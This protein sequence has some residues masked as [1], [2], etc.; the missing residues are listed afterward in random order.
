[1][2]RFDKRALGFVPFIFFQVWSGQAHADSFQGVLENNRAVHQFNKEELVE[3][4][5]GFTKALGDLTA[6]AEVHFNLGTAFLA[7]KEPKKAIQEFDVALKMNPIDELKYKISFNKADAYIALKRLPEALASY[8]EALGVKPDSREVKFN[9]ELLIASS[10]KGDGDGDGKSDGKDQNKQDK[11][12]Q[13]DQQNQQ[14]QKDQERRQMPQQPKPTPKP[15]SSD[16]LSKQDVSRILEELKR[17][18]DQIRERMQREGGR[19][20]PIGN[21]W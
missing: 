2:G 20:A 15:F 18:E 10:A 11:Q 16:Q 14:K 17:Q 8:Q 13:Q 1:M 7:A 3:A 12:N 5:A 4:K 21:D 19:D 6:R 9:I